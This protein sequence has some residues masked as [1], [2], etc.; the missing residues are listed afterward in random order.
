MTV[1]GAAKPAG[2][3]ARALARVYLATRARAI[4]E[5]RARD[6][7]AVPILN[8]HRV[9]TFRPEHPLTILP[10][11]FR[12]L[13]L[14]LRE[15]YRFVSLAELDLVLSRGKNAED[16]VA[17]TFD[18]SYGCLY[19]H[20]FPILR[21]LALPATFFVS[22]GFVDSRTPM[23]HDRKWGFLDLPSFTSEQ[24]R[25]IAATEGYELG[26][27]TVSHVDLATTTDRATI[28]RE[29]TESRAA[30]EAITGRPVT[31]LAI[32]YGTPEHCRRPEVLALA[33][34]AGYERVYSQFGG[35]N[36]VLEGGSVGY[37]L[38]R[39]WIKYDSLGHVRA[40]LEGFRG[41]HSYL[42][43]GRPE[44][45]PEFHPCGIECA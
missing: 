43:G 34:E 44:W 30:L 12:D 36:L 7:R 24:L 37:V 11:R 3:G 16:L 31:R 20:A 45:P 19:E 5:E 14:G 23:E 8:A 2:L 10:G 13:L 27:H 4:A 17:L 40:C 38:H 1:A 42:P 35:R 39:T 21:E 29:L 32:P 41:R 9:S 15:S 28:A 25:A 33:R 18:D 22:T 26:S 6:R